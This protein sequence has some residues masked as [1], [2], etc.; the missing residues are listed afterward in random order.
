MNNLPNQRRTLV[1]PLTVTFKTSLC[2]IRTGAASVV[3]ENDAGVQWY[4]V[5]TENKSGVPV[6]CTVSPEQVVNVK[7]VKQHH[8]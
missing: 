8:N 4:E 5:T 6:E 2:E 7:L 1:T 3:W